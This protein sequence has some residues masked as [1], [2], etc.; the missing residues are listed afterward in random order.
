MQQSYRKQRGLTL[1]S[2]FMLMGFIGFFVLLILKVGPIYLDHSKV[3]HSLESLKSRADIEKNTKNEIWTLLRKQLDM[4][5]ISHIKKKDV[6]IKI[7]SNYL[8][9]QI[10]Y[11][12]KQPLFSNL[13]VWVDF[14]NAIEVGVQ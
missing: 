4:N 5:S 3:V 2:F 11:H 7:R 13:S 10:I 12:V 8:K 1:I 6:H 14:D 9:V